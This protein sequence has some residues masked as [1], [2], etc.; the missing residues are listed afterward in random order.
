MQE[1]VDGGLGEKG[2][3][4]EFISTTA[5]VGGI[6]NPCR[7]HWGLF[8]PPISRLKRERFPRFR[9]EVAVPPALHDFSTICVFESPRPLI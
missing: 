5:Q 3:M 9:I 6:F 8:L 2:C 4:W 7:N 1:Q